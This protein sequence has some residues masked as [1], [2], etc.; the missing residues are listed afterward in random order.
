MRNRQGAALGASATGLA[1][2][3]AGHQPCA[4]H[5]YRPSVT[6]QLAFGIPRLSR[7]IAGL[8]LLDLPLGARHVKQ[9]PGCQC[10]LGA[11]DIDHAAGPD[12]ALPMPGLVRMD[13][14]HATRQQLR[15]RAHC[16]AGA[17]EFD[18]ARRGFQAAQYLQRTVDAAGTELQPSSGIGNDHRVLAHADGAVFRRQ[19]QAARLALQPLLLS[20][21]RDRRH[22][23][24]AAAGRDIA[25]GE[26]IEIDAGCL[27]RHRHA[28]RHRNIA[29]AARG[30]RDM[31]ETAI[32][33]QAGW[34]QH[35]VRRL[36]RSAQ[37]HRRSRFNE[38]AAG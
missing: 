17:T 15:I 25:V 31:A 36:R 12:L 28:V 21:H 3:R 5:A 29:G 19:R 23:G 22:L 20:Q 30:D 2:Q 32:A 10:H 4:T 34:Q 24:Q 38:Q 14:C 18:A 16:D 8:G 27:L 35:D 33:I 26:R 1:C 9:R 6:C 11:A 7:R 13:R 37:L